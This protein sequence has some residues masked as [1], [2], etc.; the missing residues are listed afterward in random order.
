[1]AVQKFLSNWMFI[2]IGFLRYLE[3]VN[4]NSVTEFQIENGGSIIE[5]WWDFYRKG[6]LN[7]FGLA[8]SK[9]FN[10]ITTFKMVDA[11]QLVKN[12]KIIG[13]S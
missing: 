12:F 2:K 11:I 9:N 4:P 10:R 7:V 5:K 13:C 8:E 6:F 1:M 3:S